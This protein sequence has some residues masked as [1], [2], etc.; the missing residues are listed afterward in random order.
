MSNTQYLSC[1]ETAKMI[2]SALK[3]SFPGI[4]FGVTSKT[5][6][7]GAS[8]RVEWRDGPPASM[9]KAIT[10]TFERS[11]FDGM[12]DYKGAKYHAIDGQPTRFGADFVFTEHSYSKARRVR[13]ILP[14]GRTERSGR[15]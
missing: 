11:Y 13:G 10:D 3:E 1:A 15:R 5:Y 6:S 8:I 12:I 7:G 14:A 9:V 4:K 2:R